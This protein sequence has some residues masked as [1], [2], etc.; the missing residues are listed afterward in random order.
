MPKHFLRRTQHAWLSPSRWRKRI[1]FWSGALAVGLAAVLFAIGTEHA[2]TAF[3]RLVAISP[4]LPLL[5]TPLGFVAVAYITRRF[6]PGSQGSGIPQTIAALQIKDDTARGKLLSLPIAISKIFLTLLALLSGASV[7]RE[8]PTVQVGAS[9]LHVVGTFAR[10]SRLEAERALIVAGGAAGVAAAFNTPLAGVVFA[11]EE[12]SRSLEE[13]VS[14]TMLTAVIVAGI[15]SMAILGNY[16]YFGHTSAPFSL[17]TGWFAPLVCGVV[18]GLLGGLFSRTLILLSRG[19]PGRLGS[20]MR[21]HPLWT[22]AVCGLLLAIVGIVSGGT[23]YGTGYHEAKGILEGQGE[24]SATY[25]LLK[26]IATLLS[27]ASGIPGGIFA[28]SLAVGAG[29]GMDLGM[30]FPLVSAGSV[31]VMAMVAYFAGVVQA[32]ITAFV[33]VMEMTDNH[34]L[35]IPLMVAAMMA[36]AVSKLVCPTPLYRSL[37]INFLPHRRQ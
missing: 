23:V 2:H 25:G 35:I 17:S 32:P 6:F 13:R 31:A 18:G 21:A 26:L 30:L 19:W 28:P 36:H 7:G 34:D 14:G 16:T 24:T 33:I 37:A 4:W 27:Y 9:I 8:G 11:I 10:F 29:F 20:L 5:V 1:I 15:T 22:A 3:R 12:M